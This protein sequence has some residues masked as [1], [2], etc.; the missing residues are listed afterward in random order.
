MDFSLSEEQQEI[1]NLAAEILGDHAENEKLKVIDQQEDRF[2]EKLWGELGKAGLLGVAIDEE[3]GGMGFGYESLCLLVEEVGRTVAPVPVIPVLVSAALPL[4]QFGSAEQKERWLSRVSSGDTL[5]TAAMIEPLNEDPLE[6]TTRAEKSGDGWSISGEKYCVPFAHRADRV[7]VAA[8][9]D[10]GLLIVWLDP[11]ASGV[12]LERQEATAGEP[13]F[14]LR[15][16]GVSVT[17]GDVMAIGDQAREIMDWVDQRT[18]AALAQ[19]AVG[20]TE[21]MVKMTA[22]YTSEREQ[23]G[24]PIA[25][26]QAVGHRAADCFIE[27]ECLRSVV[28]QAVS[29]LHSGQSAKS[30]VQVAKIWCGDVCHRV[31]QASQ[32]LHGGIGVDR[33]YPL[34]RYCLWCKQLELQ[35]GASVQLLAEFG[36][37]IA[38]EFEARIVG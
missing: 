20:V 29:I 34:F 32:H 19:M 28:Q 23:F 18:T 12:T 6:P 4:A 31:S 16:D 30:E 14:A 8:A 36:Q 27:V 26:F 5:L 25:T 22:E 7:L 37:A 24:V 17:A 1:C 21:R 13:Q 38:D 11:K 33:D 35:A 10:E 3:F 2:D 9:S 15:M